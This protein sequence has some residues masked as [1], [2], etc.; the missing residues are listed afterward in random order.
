MFVKAV[1]I[2]LNGEIAELKTNQIKLKSAK[3]IIDNYRTL[4][5]N[6]QVTQLRMI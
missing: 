6:C 5:K 4:V 2:K 1:I 3:D